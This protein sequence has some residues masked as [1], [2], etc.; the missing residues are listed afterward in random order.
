MKLTIISS[1]KKEEHLVAWIEINTIEGNCIIQ[2]DHAPTTYILSVAQEFLYCLKIGK[3]ET[4]T[5]EKTAI[6][7]VNR[8]EAI[9]I[10]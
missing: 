10:L 4:I 6:L 8:K 5:I 3:H 7:D 2:P 9:L 1:K